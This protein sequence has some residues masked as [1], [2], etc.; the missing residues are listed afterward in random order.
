VNRRS[1]FDRRRFLQAAGGMTLALPLLSSLRARGT[2]AP[3]PKRFITM[4]TPNGQISDTWFPKTVTSETD[5]V[6]NEAHEPLAAHRDK[7]VLFKGLDLAIADEAGGG[8]GGPHQRGIGALYCGQHLQT[9]EFTDGCGSKA[10]WANGISIDQEVAN[11][12]GADTLFK[13][14]EIGIR[15]TINEVEGRIS[16]TGAGAPLPP[17]LT[18]LDM[19]DRLFRDLPTTPPDGGVP[20]EDPQIAQRRSVLNSVDQQ[21]AL[22]STKV[23]AEDKLKLDAHLDLVR[24]I[25]RRLNRMTILCEKPAVPPTLDPASEVD[26]PTI[27]ETEIDMLALAFACDLTRVASIMVSSGKNLIRYPWLNYTNASGESA[28][29]DREGHPLSH[30]PQTDPNARA[31]FTVRARWHAGLVARLFDKLSQIPEGEG[32]AADNTLLVWC[33]EVSQGD[34]HSHV[35]MPFLVMG[36]GWHFATG[37]Y[38]DC[39]ASVSHGHLLVSLQNA[40][41]LPANTF[42]LPEFSNGPLPQ[43]GA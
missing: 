42:G 38:I 27:A 28:V 2:P 6:L 29:S 43:L 18:P 14:L 36:G 24:D 32:T 41:G 16:Y 37:R 39:G 22:L 31:E 15:A 7:L 4:Y 23:S 34:T 19:Y 25:E 10:G 12:I 33:S 13:S 17:M 35:N 1:L 40:M 26:M 3:F 20:P 30:N 9:G 21:L 8:P 5:F 11:H